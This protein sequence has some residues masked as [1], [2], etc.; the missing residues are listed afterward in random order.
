V[1]FEFVVAPDGHVAEVII[2]DSPDI[3]LSRTVQE[4]VAKRWSYQP[5]RS[6]GS[7]WLFSD[8][9]RKARSSVRFDAK[10]DA[11]ETATR[12][13]QLEQIRANRGASQSESHGV[14]EKGSGSFNLAW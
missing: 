7:A 2:L 12:R 10:C 8:M 14:P 13:A 4:T 3:S 9:T 1:N 6:A 5:L 11:D